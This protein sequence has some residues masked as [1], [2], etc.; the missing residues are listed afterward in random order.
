MA[1]EIKVKDE[2]AQKV[3]NSRLSIVKTPKAKDRAHIQYEEYQKESK[4]L[5]NF[6]ERKMGKRE[7]EI[8]SLKLEQPKGVPEVKEISKEKLDEKMR[9]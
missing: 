1:K 8:D 5:L 7:R 3:L 4:G 6:C 2:I 9:K